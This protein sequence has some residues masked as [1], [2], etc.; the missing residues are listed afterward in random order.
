M[1]DD[2]DDGYE[3]GEAHGHKNEKVLD[4]LQDLWKDFDD[5]CYHIQYDKNVEINKLES[6]VYSLEKE[7]YGA[8]FMLGV[9]LDL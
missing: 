5:Y 6:K 1:R 2:Y 7:K 3:W 4:A 9:K 8:G